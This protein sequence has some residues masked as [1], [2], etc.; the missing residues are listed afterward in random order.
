MIDPESITNSFLQDDDTEPAAPELPVYFDDLGEP[1]PVDL[2]ADT[3]PDPVDD[4]RRGEREILV[5]LLRA[6][7]NIG[8]ALLTG[9]ALH[10][11]AFKA[12]QSPYR[13]QKELASALKISEG[14]VS[15]ISRKIPK[16]FA[17]L[18]RLNHRARYT[19]RHR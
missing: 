13:T 10:V 16:K 2:P 5:G 19:S 9:Q 3:E 18:M 4:A 17:S 12:G 1:V 14:R 6:I 8:P 15:Q 11:L 7:A